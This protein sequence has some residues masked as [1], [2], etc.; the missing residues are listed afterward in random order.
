MMSSTVRTG[1][2]SLTVVLVTGGVASRAGVAAGVR[3]RAAEPASPSPAVVYSRLPAP[4]DAK[5]ILN[6]TPRHREWA[7]VPVEGGSLLA[8]MV[9]PERSDEA[10]VVV[11]DGRTSD[12]SDWVRAVGD[13]LAAEGFI[14]MAPSGVTTA[15]GAKA[16]RTYA[17]G[18]PSAD[19]QV[20]S[21]TLDATEI[22]VDAPG[23]QANRA[24]FALADPSW[25]DLVAFLNRTTGNHPVRS[26][27]PAD[28]H[29]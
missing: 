17:L 4:A 26:A 1:L 22:R 10:P 8:W 9:Y 3:A 7:S 15:D 14:T 19:G 28:P 23:S 29:A 20:V 2:A 18:L 27:A 25:P 13:Q 5:R 16:I 21:L 11:L 24:R 6:T 12:P